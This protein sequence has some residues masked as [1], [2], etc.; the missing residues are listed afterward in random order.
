MYALS[1]WAKNHK[2][3]ARIT[4]I[5]IYVLL[6]IISLIL[7]NWLTISHITLP[8]SF[9]Y[10]IALLF[11]TGVI[12]YPPLEKKHQY[13]HFYIARKTADGIL[14][15]S[16]FLMMIWVANNIETFRFA[17]N[18]AYAATIHPVKREAKQP[19]LKT[20]F[21]L[22]NPLFK[23]LPKVDVN[24]KVFK[25]LKANIHTIRQAYKD[26]SKGGK[27]ALII[28]SILVATGLLMLLAGL[29]CNISC[30]GSDGLAILVAV[31]GTA[32]IIFLFVKVLQA[33]NRG[34]RKPKPEP[35]PTT[36]VSF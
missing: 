1:I 10:S 27:I 29:S 28:L 6:H 8:A 18:E 36:Q 25:K 17:T 2:R 34:P 14:A 31:L 16:T 30:S 21:S 12:I 35:P 15:F 20:I 13:R 9:F 19:L 23:L 11:F 22:K 32:L 33:I 26:T 24:S 4:I 3:A 7:G 5:S